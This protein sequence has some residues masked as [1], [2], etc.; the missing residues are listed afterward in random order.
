MA[1]HVKRCRSKIYIFREIESNSTKKFFG[2]WTGFLLIEVG[3]LVIEGGVLSITP[4]IPLTQI[5]S[6]QLYSQWLTNI[7]L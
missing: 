1:Q 3:I 5:L 6:S 2:T 4:K 7:S